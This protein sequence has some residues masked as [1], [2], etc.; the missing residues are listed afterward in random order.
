MERS[1]YTDG[2]NSSTHLGLGVVAGI[3]LNP[4]LIGS[5]LAYQ[6]T[7]GGP[8]TKVDIVEFL[9]PLLIVGGITVINRKEDN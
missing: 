2:I 8:N 6:I 4:L 7:Q 9:I 1:L 5:Y 3:T